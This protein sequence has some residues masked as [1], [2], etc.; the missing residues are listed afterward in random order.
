MRALC[1]D[2]PPEHWDTGDRG[3][4]LALALCRVCPARDGEVCTV[5]QPDRRPFGVIRAGVAYN[6]RGRR[7][8]ICD[9]GYPNDDIDKGRDRPP[10]CRQCR[11]PVLRSWA[12]TFMSRREYNAAGYERRKKQ[13][14]GKQGRVTVACQ[15]NT[16]E[17]A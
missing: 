11:V 12:R 5:G 17:G 1:V 15:H 16:Y 3:N 10:G 8:E 4:R 7:C 14:D 13:R 6:E 9:C 2:Q